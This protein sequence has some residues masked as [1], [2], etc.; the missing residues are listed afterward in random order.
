MIDKAQLKHLRAQIGMEDI[1]VTDKDVDLARV[2][3]LIA[4]RDMTK[5]FI[6]SCYKHP[7]AR[8]VWVAKQMQKKWFNDK[9]I[10]DGRDIEECV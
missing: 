9:D 5:V 4:Q 7:T 10:D 8:A 1:E 3:A 2:I 6:D